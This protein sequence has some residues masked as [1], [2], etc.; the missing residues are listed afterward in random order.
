[1]QLHIQ[2]HCFKTCSVTI[3]QKF[4][5]HILKIN[6]NHYSM[7]HN[8]Y[9]C[10]CTNVIVLLSQIMLLYMYTQ[11]DTNI[12]HVACLT[13]N[14]IITCNT[15]IACVVE[16]REVSLGS[17]IRFTELVVLLVFPHDLLHIALVGS[18]GEPTLFV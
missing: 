7:K 6:F 12:V 2:I 13:S 5:V 4:T 8:Y 10:T 1:M 15:H 17:E 11:L 16:Q 9:K 3:V 18:F 14:T